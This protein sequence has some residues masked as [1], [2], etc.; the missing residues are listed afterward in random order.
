MHM[1]R[2]RP[3]SPVSKSEP[4]VWLKKIGKFILR[5]VIV[6]ELEDET[7]RLEMPHGLLLI[8]LLQSYVGDDHGSYLKL[9]LA[10]V[11]MLLIFL[12]GS[13]PYSCLILWAMYCHARGVTQRTRQ[14]SD[15]CIWDILVATRSGLEVRVRS[16][17]AENYIKFC[18]LGGWTSK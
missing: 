7:E 6:N 3:G 5:P 14:V 11:P 2:A 12:Y 18:H 13:W 17:N 8:N 10:I 1:E 4:F 15:K 16:L 9:V